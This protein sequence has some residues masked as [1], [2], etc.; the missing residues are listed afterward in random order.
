MTKTAP[1]VALIIA[2]MI[3]LH[4]GEEI[5]LSEI[6]KRLQKI[7][8]SVVASAHVP[9]AA[10]KMPAHAWAT[11]R[12]ENGPYW[13]STTSI[14]KGP[15]YGLVLG[16]GHCVD[17]HVGGVC[18]L[19]RPDG[20]KCKA[21]LIDFHH[22][23]TEDDADL[24][25]FRIAASDVIAFTQVPEEM[26]K[27]APISY[28]VIGYPRGQGPIYLPLDTPG[29]YGK[30][31][32]TFRV[33]GGKVNHGNSGCG[34]FV[35]GMLCGV[36]H[37]GNSV[38]MKAVPL[39]GQLIGTHVF[40]TNHEQIKVFLKK[41]RKHFDDSGNPF[42]PD[43]KCNPPSGFN[44]TPNVPLPPKPEGIDDPPALVPVPDPKFAEVPPPI[45]EPPYNGKGKPPP[46]L[47]TPRERSAAIDLLRHEQLDARLKAVE[48]ALAKLPTHS[49]LASLQ[50]QLDQI[51]GLIPGGSSGPGDRGPQGPAGAPG[52]PGI[53][54]KDGAPGKD[55]DPAVLAAIQSRLT[56]VETFQK[57]LTGARLS[58]N[59][60]T[61]PKQ[62]AAV[63][64]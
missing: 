18:T 43:G 55:V 22:Q 57:N 52:A 19:N 23:A 34:V 26:P 7:E 38:P 51:K 62:T 64:P 59:V 12:M 21:E 15:K 6:K 53:A 39:S 25:L 56:A 41:N 8:Y 17:G 5:S 32:W 14:S 24:S 40:C 44:P 28:D 13:C 10:E 1:E 9:L 54:G 30:K 46:D 2:G 3:C 35:N 33:K 63:S 31:M 61:V 36:T 60:R 27:A 58:G 45:P 48:A 4:A 49:D 42:C 50:S 29:S 16:C 47:R 11:A 37:G 20:S